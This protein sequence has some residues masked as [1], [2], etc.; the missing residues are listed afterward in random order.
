[1]AVPDDLGPGVREKGALPCKAKKGAGGTK[2]WEGKAELMLSMRVWACMFSI[3]AS[4]GL[5]KWPCVQ[6]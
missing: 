6:V 5:A 2:G 4:R 3:L 1:M